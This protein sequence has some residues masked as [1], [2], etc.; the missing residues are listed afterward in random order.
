M[1]NADKFE[2]LRYGDNSVLN[3]ATSYLTKDG[4]VIQ[5]KSNTRDLGVMMSDSGQFRDHLY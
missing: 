3:D 5:R 4:I 1:F 2:L